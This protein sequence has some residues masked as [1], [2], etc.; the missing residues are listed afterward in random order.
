MAEISN[1]RTAQHPEYF[2]A[3]SKTR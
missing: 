2:G 3:K 1:T